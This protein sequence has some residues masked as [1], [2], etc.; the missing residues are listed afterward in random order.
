MEIN[1][2]QRHAKSQSQTYTGGRGEV[3]V[4]YRNRVDRA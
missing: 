1:K 2:L 4:E 3:G